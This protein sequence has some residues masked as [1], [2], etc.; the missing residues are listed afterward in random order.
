[1][2]FK[3]LNNIFI[4]YIKLGKYAI[5]VQRTDSIVFSIDSTAFLRQDYKAVLINALAVLVAMATD[6]SFKTGALSRYASVL[7]TVN[8][9]VITFKLE[10][11][12]DILH[13]RCC[14][15]VV[16]TR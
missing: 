11:Y 3:I 14:L 8:P 9:S 16:C 7:N 4:A 15:E 10:M 2:G 12:D 13:S 5:E 1:M 6:C